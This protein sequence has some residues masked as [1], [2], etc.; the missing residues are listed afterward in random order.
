[1][2][3]E[4]IEQAY[5]LLLENTKLIESKL[6]ISIYEAL[7]EQNAYYL[8]EASDEATIMANNGRL[9]ELGL[10]AEE[11]RRSFQF[12]FLKASQE[13]PLQANHQFTPDSIGFIIL[14]L[15]EELTPQLS[16]FDLLE[17]GSGTGNLAETLVI[18]SRKKIDYLGIEADDLLIDLSASIADVIGSDIRFVQEDAVRPQILKESDVIV[19]DLPIGYYPHDHL[20]KRYQV[21]AKTGH[22]YAHHLL[23]EQA[24]KYLKQD[25]IAIFLAPSNLLT[26]EQSALLKDWLR[27]HASLLA[28]VALPE[29][30]FGSQQYVK[31]LFVLQKQRQQPVEA[32][33]Y[34]LSD[35]QNP[36]AITAFMK[37]FQNW[38]Q[39]SAI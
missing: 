32:F 11:W 33:V 36:D 39:E 23:M 28:V 2:N 29:A 9:R 35:L 38:K 3:F 19:S 18:N 34:P 5:Q 1:M 20:A 12:L 16:S 6:D 17:I 24:L 30:F 13:Q 21:G 15:L 26:S 7:I 25:G 14:Y 31:S 27:H 37:N 10:T 22:T 8:G 4:K